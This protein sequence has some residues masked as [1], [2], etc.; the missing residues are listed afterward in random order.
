MACGRRSIDSYDETMS[1]TNAFTLRVPYPREISL[2]RKL[3]QAL[4][5]LLV[6][7]VSLSAS[8]IACA[9][10]AEDDATETPYMRGVTVSC[11]RDG[12]GEWDSPQMGRTID[13]IKSLG[14]GW[15]SFHPYARIWRDGSVRHRAV[16]DDSSV[17]EPLRMAKESGV[18]VM[19]I[20]HIGYWGSGFDW[21]GDIRFD[22]EQAWS[23]F[24]EQYTAFIVHQA[25]LAQ[26]GGAAMFC[27]GIEYKATSHREADWRKVIAAVREVFK[28]PIT[29]AANWDEYEKVKFWDALDYIGI[30][31]YFPISTDESPD[32]DA[33][34][35]GW[36]KVLRSVEA[37][38]KQHDRP[39]I[40][41]ELGYS[42]ASTAASEPWL[43]EPRRSGDNPHGEA[44]KLQCM[45]VAL[46][47][48]EASPRVHGVFLWKWFPSTREIER[49]FVL[50]YPAM[51]QL[52]ADAWKADAPVR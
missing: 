39:V 24:F 40:F 26:R 11:F 52:L 43:S 34:R 21:R 29:Y 10:A 17:L 44:L 28:G 30:Q 33:L 36:Q 42:R 3:R 50:Q 31:A 6:L 19:L 38:A 1:A 49:D 23:R 7:A 35:K 2:M 25:E 12:P 13:E 22:D 47:L 37:F 15:I 16:A 45:R 27:V 8:P 32:D 5:S 18:S 4:F 48:V 14:G 20:P 9:N 41:T 51:N 46:P